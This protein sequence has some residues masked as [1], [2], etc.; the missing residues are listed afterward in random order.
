LTIKNSK[1]WNYI[2]SHK[3]SGKALHHFTASNY[4][5]NPDFAHSAAACCISTMPVENI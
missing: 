3:I 5:D 2:G 1:S 4:T